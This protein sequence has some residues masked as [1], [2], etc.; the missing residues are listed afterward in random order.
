M[1]YTLQVVAQKDA[2]PAHAAIFLSMEAVFAGNRG[3]VA[4]Q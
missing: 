4:P 2:H 1:A 3:M